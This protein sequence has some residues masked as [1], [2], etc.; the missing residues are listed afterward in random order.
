MVVPLPH[1][2]LHAIGGKDDMLCPYLYFS[3][4][5][6]RLFILCM[7]G[8]N[9]MCAEQTASE[10]FIFIIYLVTNFHACLVQN[11]QNELEKHDFLN[12]LHHDSMTN[13]HVLLK[14][15]S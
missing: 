7:C 13:F 4:V 9:D 5:Q 10:T 15:S 2:H 12:Q 11:N 8:C 1:L 14:R 3:S 6:C